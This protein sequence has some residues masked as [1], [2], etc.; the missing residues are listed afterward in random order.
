MVDIPSHFQDGYAQTSRSESIESIV[1]TELSSAEVSHSESQT[2][3]VAVAA[4]ETQSSTV[5]TKA[6]EVQSHLY[7]LAVDETQTEVLE[8]KNRRLQ[9]HQVETIDGEA[10]TESVQFQNKVSPILSMVAS[11][12]GILFSS[13]L[14]T[15]NSLLF[16]SIPQFPFQSHRQ[17][18]TF[19]IP[20][21]VEE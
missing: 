15:H 7:E 11:S 4:A 2:D 18:A 12:C 3:G 8:T 9:T 1:Q 17:L 21:N 19:L 16:S 6:Q 13:S 10:Q 20:C 5:E 14:P